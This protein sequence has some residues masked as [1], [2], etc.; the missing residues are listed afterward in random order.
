MRRSAKLATLAAITAVALALRLW[1]AETA[2]THGDETHYV[3]DAAWAYSGLAPT[4][5]VSFL[6]NHPRDHVFIDRATGSL[7]R[8]GEEGRYPHLGHPTLYAIV[9]GTLTAATPPGSPE[10]AI[11]YGR[12]LN[13]VADTTCVLLLPLLLTSLGFSTRVGIVAALLYAVYPPAVTYGSLA[14]LDPFLAP[15][16][17]AALIPIVRGTITRA[18]WICSGIAT[19]L[20]LATKQ[21]GLVALVALPAIALARA[22][23]SYRGL[24]AWVASTLAVLAVF[25]NPAAYVDCVLHPLDPY[26]RIRTNPFQTLTSNLYFLSRPYEYYW[27]SYSKHAQPLAAAIAPLH[28]VLS[29]V[30]LWLFA[31]SLPL[32]LAL[33]RW[34]VALALFVPVLGVLLLLPPSDG[35]WR[36]HIVAPL[37]AAGA[38]ITLTQGS[39]IAR[40][41]ALAIAILVGAYHWSPAT[42]ARASLADFLRADSALASSQ[43]S[44]VY[45]PIKKP[46]VIYVSPA[47]EI[48]RTLW[49]PPGSYEID[50]TATTW[51]TVALND[52]VL[53][54]GLSGTT[55]F[56]VS[57]Y[58]H[59]LEL[60]FL[61][62]GILESFRIRPL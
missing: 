39:R 42:A 54:S 9:L 37:I 21:T 59:R 57:R 60:R 13:A 49:L 7:E 19:G 16:F 38:A 6:W 10:A 45:D 50:S 15:L 34:A 5:A 56:D 8:W 3:G 24:F 43:P 25:A 28:H 1:N 58:F 14:Y 30:I 17:L 36:A 48:R 27:L 33:R 41:A 12:I 23:Q 55:K 18:G 62:P 40:G 53:I 22:P 32:T 44:G 46:L 20:L 11:R 2:S 35:A 51:M 52:E 4:S 47:R 29:P 26:A 61:E 31:S